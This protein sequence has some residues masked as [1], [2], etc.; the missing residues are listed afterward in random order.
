MKKMGSST[1]TRFK[2]KCFMKVLERKTNESQI[3]VEI[4][5][6]KKWRRN[7]F[8]KKFFLAKRVGKCC[9]A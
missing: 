3:G 5:W 1:S 4:C 8:T 2:G 9:W 7:D 6:S